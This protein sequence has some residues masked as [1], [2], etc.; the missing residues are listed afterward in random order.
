MHIDDVRNMM[1]SPRLDMALIE[2]DERHLLEEG[3][4]HWGADVVVLDRPTAIE[5]ETLTR[6]LLPDGVVVEVDEASDRLT[7]TS[8]DG[9]SRTCELE[10]SVAGSLAG[11]LEPVLAGLAELY[12]VHNAVDGRSAHPAKLA[13]EADGS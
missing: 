2:Y 5:R 1:R 8:C 7:V 9:E 6:D 11:V 13:L 10:D 12:N 4:Y 3:L